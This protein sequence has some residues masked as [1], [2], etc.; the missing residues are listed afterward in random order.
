MNNKQQ[1]NKNKI[2]IKKCE[3]LWTCRNTLFGEKTKKK[4]KCSVRGTELSAKTYL[5]FPTRRTEQWTDVLSIPQ[6]S[7]WFFEIFQRNVRAVHC[8][9]WCL[10]GVFYSML[11]SIRHWM[12]YRLLVLAEFISKSKYDFKTTD[13]LI[14]RR[15]IYGAIIQRNCVWLGNFHST[16]LIVSARQIQINS[17]Y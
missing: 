8:T 9:Y 7:I 10:R 4:K 6:R 5:L 3:A 2:K 12:Q 17:S 16:V 13:W 15:K 1:K 14:Q 11:V